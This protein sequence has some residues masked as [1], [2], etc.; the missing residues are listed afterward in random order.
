MY[1]VG[2]KLKVQPAENPEIQSLHKITIVKDTII[3]GE[4][5]RWQ[6]GSEYQAMWGQVLQRNL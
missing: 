1:L 4:K 5:Y 2:E 3:G 6:I